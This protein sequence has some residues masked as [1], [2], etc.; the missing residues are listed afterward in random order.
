[1]DGLGHSLARRTLTRAPGPWS[2]GG[3]TRTHHSLLITPHP[4]PPPPR[5]RFS[6]PH[7]A[8]DPGC[9]HAGGSP[10]ESG[11]SCRGEATK[12]GSVFGLMPRDTVFFDLFEQAAAVNLRAAEAYAG[13]A[14]DY[15]RRQ[16][17]IGRIRE[18]EHDGDDIAHR[19]L[20]KLDTSFITP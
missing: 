10:S 20:Q 1:P 6:A 17:L 5:S 2:P 14:Q 9:W 7:V 11:S 19:T 16:E 12:G 3:P 13:L 4:S 8:L 18:L 15:E